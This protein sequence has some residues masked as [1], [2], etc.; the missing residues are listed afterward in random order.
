MGKV[1]FYRGHEK[2]FSVGIFDNFRQLSK[3]QSAVGQRSSHLYRGHE[4][5]FS[6]GIFDNFRSF[7][8]L[9]VSALLLIIIIESLSFLKCEYS[10]DNSFRYEQ[11]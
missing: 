3:F 7:R 8:A 2:V 9:L 5:V 11:Q 1:S 4:K 6:V 10:V